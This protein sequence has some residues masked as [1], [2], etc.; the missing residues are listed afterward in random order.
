MKE[1]LP[2]RQQRDSPGDD[3][4]LEQGKLNGIGTKGYN[5]DLGLASELKLV[6]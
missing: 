2:G 3:E 1:R 6:K 4:S 5:K